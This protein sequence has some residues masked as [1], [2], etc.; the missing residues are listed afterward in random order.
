[1]PADGWCIMIRAFGSAQRL[2]GAPDGEQELAHA[3]G[4]S[5]GERR[6]VVGDQPHRVVDRQP[7]RD[8]AARA[9][10]VQADVGARV[11]RRQ[12]EQLGADPVRRRPRRPGCRAAR[13]AASSSCAARWSSNCVAG[14]SPSAARGGGAGSR[15]VD[16]WRHRS[17]FSSGTAAVAAVCFHCRADALIGTGFLARSRFAQGRADRAGEHGRPAGR[18]A[19]PAGMHE[20][21]AREDGS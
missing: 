8:R 18:G 16:Q 19:R 17:S 5:H 21:G 1:M 3:G 6:D 9:V 2:P 12:Q 7:R 4:E 10:D 13:S 11:L 20:P 14:V 15:P